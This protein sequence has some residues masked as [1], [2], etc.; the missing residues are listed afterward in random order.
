MHVALGEARASVVAAPPAPSAWHQAACSVSVPVF[1]ALCAVLVCVLTLHQ[2]GKET[3]AKQDCAEFVVSHESSLNHCSTF[4]HQRRI[5]RLHPLA[6][7]VVPPPRPTDGSVQLVAPV[8][9]PRVLYQQQCTHPTIESQKGRVLILK[10]A[11]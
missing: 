6:D 10:H 2:D 5:H 7:N 3:T 8:L 1:A 4:N 11:Q 9:A